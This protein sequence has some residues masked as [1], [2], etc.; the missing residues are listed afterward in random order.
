MDFIS[1]LDDNL[2]WEY[3]LEGCGKVN[4]DVLL[5][6]Q[7]DAVKVR[8]RNVGSAVIGIP[9]NMGQWRIFRTGEWDKRSDFIVFGDR[10]GYGQYVFLIELKTTA[11]TI[12][13]HKNNEKDDGGRMELRWNISIFHYI[14]SI[15][16]TDTHFQIDNNYFTIRRFLIGKQFTRKLKRRIEKGRVRGDVFD[17]EY[18]KGVW[19][20]LLA[21]S[22][23][24]FPVSV[25]D[26]IT[27]SK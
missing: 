15:Y 25:R 10:P 9:E 12:E 7:N 3:R 23:D 21:T 1:W 18:Y 13:E 17:H 8:V 22:D 26:M 16:N 2:S 20:N 5:R 6:D 27:K 4:G 11:R 19:I 14:L 24:V